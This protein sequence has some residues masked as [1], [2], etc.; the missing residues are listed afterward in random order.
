[1]NCSSLPLVEYNQA[2]CR[3]KM[4][5]QQYEKMQVTKD[6]KSSYCLYII[7]RQ[8]CSMLSLYGTTDLVPDLAPVCGRE[9]MQMMMPLFRSVTFTINIATHGPVM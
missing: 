6:K 9:V 5:V 2:Y 1:M 8:N 7:I 3:R 4:L